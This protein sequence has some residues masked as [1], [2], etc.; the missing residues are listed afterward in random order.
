VGERRREVERLTELGRGGKGGE[1]C[2][3]DGSGRRREMERVTESY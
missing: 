2:L 1:Y 3:V